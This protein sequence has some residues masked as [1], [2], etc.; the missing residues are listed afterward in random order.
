MED[1]HHEDKRGESQ[2][3]IQ[4][5]QLKSFSELHLKALKHVKTPNQAC[6]KQ[7]LQMEQSLFTGQQAV[8]MAPPL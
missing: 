6:T 2:A 5:Q 7:N 8:Q 3:V 4:M 1:R